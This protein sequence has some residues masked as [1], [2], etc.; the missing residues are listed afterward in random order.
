MGNVK[1]KEI[2]LLRTTVKI[3]GR[4]PRGSEIPK[5]NP[6]FNGKPGS[7]FGSG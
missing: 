6:Q 5:T 2:S 1:G 3:P 4:G 7:A